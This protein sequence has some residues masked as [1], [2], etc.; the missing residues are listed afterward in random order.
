MEY[1]DKSYFW[2][3]RLLPPFEPTLRDV[4]PQAGVALT[5]PFS[6]AGAGPLR[7]FEW[8]VEMELPARYPYEPPKFRFLPG[9]PGGPPL[10]HPNVN[11]DDNVCS[12]SLPDWAP[13][14]LS[15]TAFIF[16]QAL[17]S[18][19]DATVVPA[20][21]AAA[22]LLAEDAPAFYAALRRSGRCIVDGG[23]DGGVL[24][25]DQAPSPKPAA[26]VVLRTALG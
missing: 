18:H 17:L 21:P 14:I 16:L 7:G 9:V 4:E 8:R 11:P 20:N 26:L 22:A 23:A 10:I 1:V 19:P 12:F 2:L 25:W 24:S 13:S 15:F 6:L 3:V 5:L